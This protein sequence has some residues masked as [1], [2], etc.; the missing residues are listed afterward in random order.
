DFVYK[1]TPASRALQTQ[2]DSVGLEKEAYA[3]SLRDQGKSGREI[4]RDPTYRELSAKQTALNN[5]AFEAK[6]GEGGE[7]TTTYEPG[8]S[9]TIN[10]TTVTSSVTNSQVPQTAQTRVTTEAEATR[11]Q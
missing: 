10:S 1:D 6:S 9:E 8:V 2:A 7:V 4:L 11:Q 5:R 3:Q